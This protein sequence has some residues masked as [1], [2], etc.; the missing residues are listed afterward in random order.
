[1]AWRVFTSPLLNKFHLYNN[2]LTPF[3]LFH[4][5]RYL[6]CC[7]LNYVMCKVYGHQHDFKLPSTL[8]CQTFH[9]SPFLKF[10]HKVVDELQDS[11][12]SPTANGA[13]SDVKV[14]RKKLKGKRAVVRWLK[15]FRFKKKKEF[16][17]MTTEER[18]LYKLLRARKKEEKLREALKKIEPTESSETTHDPEILT[19]EEHFFF[20]KMGLKSKNY[21]PVGRR[22]I[23][24]GVILNMH[25]HWKKHQTLQVVVKTFS[26]E[27]VRE[28]ATELARLTGGI[29]L[30]IHEDDTIIMYRGK[31]YSQPPTEIMSP[32]VTLSRKKALDKSKYRDGLRAVRRYIPKLEQELEIL[33][34]Q[35]KS[36]G[37]SNIEATEGIQISDKASVEPSSV[38]NS[39]SE[40][41]DKI[42]AMFNDNNGCSEDEEDLDSD[43]DSY[44]DKLSDIFQTDSDT[45]NLVKEE[46]PLYLDEFNNFPEQSDG[47]TDD[48]EEHLQQ[49]SFNSKNMEKDADLPKFD[50][51]DRIFLRAASFLK[52]KKK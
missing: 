44:S 27:E 26:A 23:Y 33:R 10:N 25:L 37:E 32:R 19:P 30:D 20:L 31:N 29:V 39:Q 3:F 17:R 48:F 24:Q 21:V 11:P 45:E 36:T 28:I 42:G 1:M 38:S 16:L 15:F 40:K 51:V 4:K 5:T 46:K 6:H 43:L 13:N 9:S 2:N 34:A 14:M 18:I 41:F 22:G 52:K 50:E 47:D 7:S 49:I 35:L 8:G 12:N